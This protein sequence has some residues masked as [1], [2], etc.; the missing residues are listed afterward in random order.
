M[1]DAFCHTLP[2]SEDQLLGTPE[3]FSVVTPTLWNALPRDTRFA[4]SQLS[5]WQQVKTILDPQ[6]A[7]AK[8]G[9]KGVVV[10]TLET[11]VFQSSLLSGNYTQTILCNAEGSSLSESHLPIVLQVL[12]GWF[13]SPPVPQYQD[14]LLSDSLHF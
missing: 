7:G 4:F 9:I 8:R 10:K 11:S 13:L 6:W 1:G 5:L 14:G 2:S 3:V 12:A